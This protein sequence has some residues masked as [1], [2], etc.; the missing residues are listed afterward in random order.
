[1]DLHYDDMLSELLTYDIKLPI[2]KSHNPFTKRLA[3]EAAGFT[4][5]IKEQAAGISSSHNQSSP[6]TAFIPAAPKGKRRGREDRRSSDSRS[7]PPKKARRGSDAGIVSA[8]ASESD[9]I[10]EM[11]SY[12][13]GPGPST[14]MHR[15][16]ESQEN[17]VTFGPSPATEEDQEDFDDPFPQSAPP[18]NPEISTTVE[19]LLDGSS[20]PKERQL[21]AQPWKTKTN[22]KTPTRYLKPNLPI[23]PDSPSAEE[24]IGVVIARQ[25][26]LQFITS[27]E[28]GRDKPETKGATPGTSLEHAIAVDDSMEPVSETTSYSRLR[29]PLSRPSTLTSTGEEDPIVFSESEK[30]EVVEGRSGSRSIS[31]MIAPLESKGLQSSPSIRPG[32]VQ[33]LRQIF[34]PSLKAP[35]PTLSFSTAPKGYGPG[36]KTKTPIAVPQPG[37]R[38]PRATKLSQSMGLKTPEPTSS[39]ASNRPTTSTL[40]KMPVKGNTKFGSLQA[41]S[42][43]LLPL[44]RFYGCGN[45]VESAPDNLAKMYFCQWTPYSLQIVGQARL[46]TPFP[47]GQRLGK[48]DHYMFMWNQIRQAECSKNCEAPPTVLAFQISAEALTAL[49]LTFGLDRFILEFDLGH[50]R[51]N[52]DWYG[53]L[54]DRFKS[55]SIS[56]R[57][58]DH[59]GSAAILDLARQ[60]FE[61]MGKVEEQTTLQDSRK[62]AVQPHSTPNP[63]QVPKPRSKAAPLRLRDRA[64]SP[65]AEEPLTDGEPSPP[66]DDGEYEEFPLAPNDVNLRRSKRQRAAPPAVNINDNELLFSYPPVNIT[67]GDLCRLEPDEFL[68]DTLIEFG[69]KLWQNDLKENEP[70]M[71]DDIWVFN[72]F[73]YKKLSNRKVEG[74]PS[75]K[76]W[77]SKVDIF[78]KRFIIVPINENLHWYLAI[79]YNPGGSLSATMQSKTPPP[80]P[81]TRA[82]LKQSVQTHSSSRSPPPALMPDEM[83]RASVANTDIEDSIEVD[84]DLLG[85]DIPMTSP[86][87]PQGLEPSSVVEPLTRMDLDGPGDADD[88]DVEMSTRSV[89]QTGNEAGG[90]NGAPEE[91]AEALIA[92]ASSDDEGDDR[93]PQRPPDLP[94]IAQRVLL[95]DDTSSEDISMNGDSLRPGDEPEKHK[96]VEPQTSVH[97]DQTY[98]FILDSLGSK[99]PSVFTTLREW[100]S[101]EARDKRNAQIP[102]I[103]NNGKYVKVPYQPNHVDCGVY[104]LHFAETFVAKA[105]EIVSLTLNSKKMDDASLRDRIFDKETLK[106][107][108]AVLK[109]RV[110]ELAKARAEAAS[111]T[112][113]KTLD[114]NLPEPAEEHEDVLEDVEDPPPVKSTVENTAETSKG[115]AVARGPE[116][117][118]PAPSLDSH[119]ES[120]QPPAPSKPP[121]KAL[122]SAPQP[123]A[124]S[125][126]DEI[127][128]TGYTMPPAPTRTK[129]AKS[130]PTKGKSARHK[131]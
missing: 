106:K 8:S 80:P 44:K 64:Q 11:P 90:L 109:T 15:T 100:L 48:A 72:S 115:E 19:S 108:R 22:M 94:T 40:G 68:N 121:S 85:H 96:A 33:N 49:G 131:G 35:V 51:W 111:N 101:L 10:E 17:Q 3:S 32:T 67:R 69:L 86:T 13:A 2:S 23:S 20:K 27:K 84:Q 126:D 16:R 42:D 117:P 82:S 93:V 31:R 38:G 112:S 24:D 14:I 34:D 107:K 110:M 9:E 62:S 28:R 73:F 105:D 50:N 92:Y 6:Y 130:A 39:T 75:V 81:T 122:P 114:N 128:I 89:L 56:I 97:E 25:P 30:E 76:K 4:R 95:M 123:A 127:E 129:A 63:P 65:K 45:L 58:V 59:N 77:T 124:G 102:K 78:K 66:K 57:E 36:S 83:D 21:L 46:E 1:M 74:Y 53:H 79:V 29:A 87:D 104:L 91:S 7:P 98:I 116:L 120:E 43:T 61:T 99:H 71:A 60:D 70:Q 52:S 125:D 119:P 18:R 41:S 47:Q 5:G 54:K 88:G 113:E 118:E 26:R 12:G 103:T 37:S 55:A